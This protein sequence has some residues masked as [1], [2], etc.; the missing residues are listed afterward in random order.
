SCSCTMNRWTLCEQD[1]SGSCTCTLV[2]SDRRV[3][4]STLTSKCLLMKAEMTSRKGKRF[5]SP[6]VGNEGLYS[7]DC[8]DSGGF[9]ARQCDPGDT[10][11][12]V[13]SAGVRRTEQGDRGLRCGELIRT[14]CIYMELKHSTP[15]AFADGQVANALKQL[16]QNRYK[17][18]P[19]YVAGVKYDAP[20]IQIRLNQDD[21]EKSD[22]DV[23]IADVAYYFEKDI[24]NDSIFHTN[25]KLNVSVNGKALDIENI[26]IYYIDE[27][28]P[29]FS[30]RRMISGIT[31]VV[32]VVTL[33]IIFG[34][35][36]VVILK[37]QR[38]RNYERV[39]LR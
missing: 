12:C 11:W 1:E 2:G 6:P 4:C 31:V 19:K 39:D 34:V 38:K 5:H 26:L 7:P 15:G 24:K 14:G 23:D 22:G 10:C 27:K 30:A 9:K 18:P 20:F 17:L 35:T 21:S 13:N 32:T 36:V 29:Q 3:D 16:L 28:P 8:E 37:W 25:S 33:T